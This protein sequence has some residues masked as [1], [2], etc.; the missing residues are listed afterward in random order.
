[1]TDFLDN[2]VILITGGT[3]SLGRAFCKHLLEYHRPRKVVV[4]SRD[5]MKQWEMEK[6]FAD[7]RMRYI[8]GDVRDMEHMKWAFTGVDYIVHAAADKIVDKC[9]TAPIETI[10]TNIMG[11]KNVVE[12]T[13]GLPIKKAVFISSDK[14]IAPANLY[15]ATKMVGEKLFIDANSM[16]PDHNNANISPIFS[17]TRW[18]NIENSRGA[19]IPYF[20]KC[21]KQGKKELPLHDAHCTRFILNFDEAISVLLKA[22]E[23]PPGLI[24][25]KKAPSVYIS[26]II[27]ALECE[28]KVTGLQSGE[29]L[30]ESL[31]TAEEQ[32]RAYENDDNIIV[33]PPRVFDTEIKYDISGRLP[34]THVYSSDNN[35]FLNVKQIKER[36]AAYD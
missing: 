2:K 35:T 23:G 15:G 20:K 16:R 17:C 5:T 28:A 14:A 6:E 34:V 11:T 27:L 31:L 10:K 7:S 36:M 29:K 25:I 12:A 4:Y 33:L 26:S 22:L 1:M 13:R 32:F 21:V 30:H 9:E 3:G 24:W 19:V 18:G 8:E